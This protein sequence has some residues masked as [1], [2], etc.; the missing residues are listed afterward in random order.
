CCCCCFLYKYA[1]SQTVHSYG[2]SP[3][4]VLMWT[5]RYVLRPQAF[6]QTLQTYDLTPVW[7]FMCAVRLLMRLKRRPHSEHWYGLS[8]AWTI[9]SSLDDNNRSLC[10]T[11]IRLGTNILWEP[12]FPKSPLATQK[13]Q[14][15]RQFPKQPPLK[16]IRLGI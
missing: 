8:L 6:P 1:L 5:V 16:A 10:D 2:L 11:S 12:L 7:I 15:G 13:I 4:C 14:Y 9:M 3:L